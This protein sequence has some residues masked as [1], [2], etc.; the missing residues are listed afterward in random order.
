M[1]LS[2]HSLA[3]LRQPFLFCILSQILNSSCPLGC[4]EAMAGL[5]R[6]ETIQGRLTI[7]C[8]SEVDLSLLLFQDYFKNYAFLS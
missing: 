6:T 4:F 7:A 1:D 3:F 8:A 5:F 2:G